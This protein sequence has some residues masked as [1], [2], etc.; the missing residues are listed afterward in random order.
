MG[1]TAATSAN[2]QAAASLELLWLRLLLCLNL[3]WQQ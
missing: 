3:A 1:M 2:I